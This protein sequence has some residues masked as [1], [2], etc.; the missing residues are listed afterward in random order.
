MFT[1]GPVLSEDVEFL[2]DLEMVRKQVQEKKQ[3]RSKMDRDSQPHNNNPHHTNVKD[4]DQQ[5]RKD[6]AKYEMKR[7][8]RNDTI[9]KTIEKKQN[10]QR[11]HE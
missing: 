10:Q 9:K 11:R 1:V 5:Y 3:L 2:G 8:K 7:D 6:Q 4:K